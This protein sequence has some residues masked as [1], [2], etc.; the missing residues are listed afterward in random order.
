M[1]TKPGVYRTL[2][3][4]QGITVA[5]S[6]EI[7]GVGQAAKFT[8][9]AATI[10][11]MQDSNGGTVEGVERGGGG[12][13]ERKDPDLR[14]EGNK[15]MVKFIFAASKAGHTGTLDPIATGMLPICLGESTKL[16]QIITDAD[17]RYIVRAKL[18]QR[19]TT[20]DSEGKVIEERAVQVSEK[21]LRDA[22]ESFRGKQTQVPSMFSAIKYQGK[23]LYEYAREGKTVPIQPRPINVFD[24]KILNFSLESSPSSSSSSSSA[25]DKL[26]S[27][28]YE[29]VDMEVHVSKGTYIRTIVD[30]LGQK[31]GCGAHVVILR[32]SQ[33]TSYD[34]KRM[35]GSYCYRKSLR[36]WMEES[37]VTMERL[38]EIAKELDEAAQKKTHGKDEDS[39][40][41]PN[42]DASKPSS[43][44]RVDNIKN[45]EFSR[46]RLKEIFG[47]AVSYVFYH[48]GNEEGYVVMGS[49]EDAQNAVEFVSSAEGQTAVMLD[50]PDIK[51][52]LMSKREE[53]TY[54]AQKK[55][56]RMVVIIS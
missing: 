34:P 42:E 53:E 10:L 11:L 2:V 44:L 32:R 48:R 3:L 20:S 36:E 31:L 23:K 39:N 1:P 9:A 18:G 49:A 54:H 15:E 41:N 26:E 5:F 46:E 24:I 52:H 8:V 38:E 19:T 21:Q 55:A 14:Q 50:V 6:V 40:G 35:V 13:E 28:P 51:V 4:P 22:V 12:K 47:E 30:D 17:K 16:A 27:C 7:S 37:C 25:G 43:M 45:K 33:V 56:E 29:Y